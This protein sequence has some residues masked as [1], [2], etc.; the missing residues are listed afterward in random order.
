MKTACNGD[1]NSIR[2]LESPL[3]LTPS[4]FRRARRFLFRLRRRMDHVRLESPPPVDDWFCVTSSTTSSSLSPRHVYPLVRSW[5]PITSW[6]A[7]SCGPGVLDFA[8]RTVREDEHAEMVSLFY[9]LVAIL[10]SWVLV[11]V[12][13]SQRLACVLAVR[14]FYWPVCGAFACPSLF[15]AREA[16]LTDLL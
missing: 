5:I 14:G 2:S 11:P 6:C 13:C 12:Q 9:L 7:P 1:Q 4:G 3:H 8:S 16:R 10:Q 15:H